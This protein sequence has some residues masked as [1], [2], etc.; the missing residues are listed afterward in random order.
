VFVFAGLVPNTD[1]VP[2]GVARDAAG[3]LVTG[4]RHETALPGLYAVGAVRS[5]HVGG[6]AAV[7]GD[8]TVAAIAATERV[9]SA[10][11]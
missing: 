6:L 1:C 4:T 11:A 5:G 10:A 8:A 2:E 7:I 3:A 9:R